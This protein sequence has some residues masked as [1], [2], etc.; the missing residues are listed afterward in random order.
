ME[1]LEIIDIVIQT[2]EAVP[3]VIGNTLVIVVV[4]KYEYLQTRTNMFVLA[5]AMSDLIVG[6]IVVPSTFAVNSTYETGLKNSSYSVWKNACLTSRFF[7][8]M[9]AMGDILSI[10]AITA[11]RYIFI[12]Y[13]FKYDGILSKKT[14]VIISVATII[15]AICL[16]IMATFGSGR[17]EYGMTCTMFNVLSPIVT[18]ALWMPL[19]GIVTVIVIVF[20][21]KIAYL[22]LSKNIAQPEVVNGN[23][24]GSTSSQSSSSTQKK[25]TKIMSQV[26]G[27]FVST[28]T[29]WF[30]IFFATAQNSDSSI[31]LLQYFATW[32]WQVSYTLFNKIRKLYILRNMN[33]G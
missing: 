14:A 23:S 10:L 18:Y 26:I 33:C 13:P 7:Q 2:L 11:E 3:C 6:L 8:H 30:V 29:A 32:F 9:G 31:V 16:S 25:V 12:N 4:C 5:L 19:F 22:A 15:L 21:S 27:I 1:T 28:Y 20:Y 17:F 24:N